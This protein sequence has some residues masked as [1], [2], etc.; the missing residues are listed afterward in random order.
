MKKTQMFCFLLSAFCFLSFG[1]IAQK[2]PV[3]VGSRGSIHDDPANGVYVSPNGNDATGTGAMGAPYKSI[4]F[5]M[6]KAGA[7]ATIILYGGTYIEGGEVRIRHSNI[8][9]KSKKG[10]WAHINLPFPAN[11]KDQTDQRSTI[12][13]NPDVSGCTLQSIEVSGGFY[14]VSLETKWDWGGPDDWMAASHIIIEDCILHDSRYEVV[15]VK[16]NCN[17]ITIRYCEIYKPAR[18]EIDEYKWLIG[19]A[20]GEAID[21]VNGDNMVVQ[22]NYIHDVNIGLYAKGGAADVLIENNR[23]ENALG[24]GIVVGFDT[25]PEWFDT[26]VN[27]KYYESIRSIVR[28][29]LIINTGW[30]GIGFYASLDAEVYN[31]TVVNAV[32]IGEGL[33]H[34]AIYFG[35]VTQDW[36]NPTGCPPNE[37]PKFHH[38]IVCQFAGTNQMIDIRYDTDTYPFALSGLNGD[39]TMNDNCYYVAGK[40][41]TFSDHRLGS[42]L[43]KGNLAAWKAHINGDNGSLEVDPVLDANYMTT[44]PQCAGMGIPY[45]LI[46]NNPVGIAELQVTSDK[47]QVYPNPTSGELTIMNNE[48]LTMN[49]V[50][51]YDVYGR[52]HLTVLQSYG[53]TVLN[54][55]IAAFASGVYFLRIQTEQGVIMKKVVKR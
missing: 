18:A 43:D 47:L 6:E 22:N 48:Q 1:V 28:H 45:P 31:N 5:A 32:S 21:N 46:I 11:I 34:T 12:R 27:P 35:I 16:P 39:P 15:K 9:I 37:N 4:N 24:G 49:S 14:A 40:S 54:L 13:F 36:E 30:E 44:N 52:K 51:V 50:E 3:Y 53:L 17:N 38:N 23:I 41:A 25:S 42:I 8:T 20:H 33:F 26:D 7:G 29:N 55:D 10:E 2:A 19:E